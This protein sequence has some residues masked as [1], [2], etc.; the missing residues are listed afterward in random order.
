[1]KL[2]LKRGENFHVFAQI[3]TYMSIDQ[4]QM[5]ITS[6]IMPQ[7]SCYPLIRMCHRP[8]N[9]IKKFIMIKILFFGNF[10]KK[11]SQSPF[12]KEIFSYYYQKYSGLGC[13]KINDTDF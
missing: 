6:F 12:M 3:I 11:I 8:F 10:S 4:A 2:Y 1:M 9:Q 13:N 5:L 7:F